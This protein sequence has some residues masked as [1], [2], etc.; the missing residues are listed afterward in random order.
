MVMIKKE[1]I[2][3]SLKEFK[4]AMLMVVVQCSFAGVN[5]LYKLATSS[6]MNLTIIAAYRFIFA[7]AFILPL[8]LFIERKNRPKLTWMV[9]FQSF[10]CGLFGGTLAQNLYLK[11]LALTS[12]TFASAMTNLI[13]AITFI[14]AICF[15]LERLNLGNLA[16]K[17]K[18]WGALMGIGGAMLLTCYKGREIDIWSTHVDLLRNYHVGQQPNV[19]VASS[20]TET[21]DRVLGCLLAV[22]SCASYAFW[23]IIQAKM[24]EKYPCHYSTTALMASMASIQS[25]VFALCSEREWSQWK[26]GWNIRLLCVAYSGMVAS[27]LM[28]TLI[29]WCVHMKGP[30]YASVFNPLMLVIVAIIGS[31]VLNEK[32]HVGSVLAAVMIILGLYLVLWGKGKE[33]KKM[34]IIKVASSNSGSFVERRP[35]SIEIVLGSTPQSFSRNN[36]SNSPGLIITTRVA[37]NDDVLE[38]E[39][40][41]PQDEIHDAHERN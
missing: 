33:M 15:R 22:G 2:W 29:S 7:T 1:K 26:L 24:G 20:H 27:G 21:R 25:I 36:S 37:P 13:P 19:H 16:G 35:E 6:G 9:L 4:P 41:H 28:V 14:L 30:V 12:A 31:L 3:G 17:A 10:L 38:D 34:N 11:A 8:A 5:I 18:V 23:L 32:L 40:H 39:S